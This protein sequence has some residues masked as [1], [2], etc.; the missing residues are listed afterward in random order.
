MLKATKI[1]LLGAAAVFGLLTVPV[2]A[3]HAQDNG[4]GGQNGGGRRGGGGGQGGGNWDPAQMRQRMMDRMKEQLDMKDDEF[5]AVEPKLEKVMTA[6]MEV[7]AGSMGGGNRGGG[8]RGGGD[9]PGG[10]TAAAKASAELQSTLDNKDA[11]PEEIKTKLEALRD[12][13]T[14]AKAELTKAQDDLKGLLTPR[15]EAVMVENGMLE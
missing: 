4:G 14:K 13:R 1:K 3:A 9:R 10:N 7:M 15:Q 12:A 5:A 11:K 6:R 2:S 8:R